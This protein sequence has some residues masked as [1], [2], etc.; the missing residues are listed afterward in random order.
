MFAVRYVSPACYQ[1]A[2]HI[3]LAA[4]SLLQSREVGMKRYSLLFN[5]QPLTQGLP[6]RVYVDLERDTL[7]FTKG[8][9][10]LHEWGTVTQFDR[11]MKDM[12]QAMNTD[13]FN[14]LR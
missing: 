3:N 1:K 5:A 14:T 11:Y 9:Y 10:S 12:T 7:Y 4:N 13:V 2:V 6:P 8:K